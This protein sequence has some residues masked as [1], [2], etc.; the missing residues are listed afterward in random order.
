MRFTKI[1]A[2][3]RQYV[4]DKFSSEYSGSVTIGTDNKELYVKHDGDIYHHET[5]KGE[6][7]RYL[8]VYVKGYSYN[9]L[10]T[11]SWNI[12][13]STNRPGD[14]FRDIKEEP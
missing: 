10:K 2:E 8:D 12:V 7:T 5:I 6:L 13:F 1:K 4:Q 3:N 11:T 9:T 14:L